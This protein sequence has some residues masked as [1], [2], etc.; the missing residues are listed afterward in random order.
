MFRKSCLHSKTLFAGGYF[1][2]QLSALL[3]A[4]TCCTPAL[5]Q[6]QSAA[7]RQKL[8]SPEKIVGDYLKAIGGKK[9]VAA[10]KDAGYEWQVMEKANESGTLRGIGRAKS[11]VK[12]PAAVRLDLSSDGSK[13]SEQTEAEPE[14]LAQQKQTPVDIFFIREGET[15]LAA[16]T[17]SA[18]IRSSNWMRVY[19]GGTRTLTD[20]EANVAKLQAALM[21]TRLV[22][23]K[24]QNVLARTASFDESGKEPAYVVEFSSR[25]GARLRY[26]FGVNSKLLLKISDD[27][28][29]LVLRFDDYRAENNLL[30]P[31]RV[32]IESGQSGRLALMLQSVS[33]NTGLNDSIFDPPGAEAIDVGALLREVD[34]NQEQLEERVGDYT[35]TEKRTERKINGRGEVT[36]ETVKVFEI[37]PIPNRRSVYKLVSENGVPLSAEKAAKEEKRV[38]E[39]LEKAQREREKQAEKRE[40]DKQQGKTAKKEEDD[41]GIADFLRAAELVSPR[42]ERLREREAIV[43]DFRPRAGYKPRNDIESIIS[44]LTGI[45]WIDPADKQVMRL[46]ARLV[47]SY[48]MGGGLLASVRPGTAFVFEQKRMD[49][50]VWLPVFSQINISAKIFLF[51]GIDVNVVQEFSNYQKFKSSFDDYKL[52]APEDKSQPP[53]KP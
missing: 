42:R 4:L 5:A 43:F 11:F 34:V 26:S 38:T 12:A 33:Y 25:N 2:L 35:Y 40:R 24:K 21:G 52:T 45:M 32:E 20:A 48:K 7:K 10:I 46:E 6:K 28:R 47:E 39:E 29:H 22:D 27:A 13:V 9:R 41:L 18:W 30:E 17:R 23:Y 49:D 36:E 16:N 3:L 50:G 15:N 14:Q 19:Q 37:Y 44:K 53:A 8:P 31:H 1:A 51:K